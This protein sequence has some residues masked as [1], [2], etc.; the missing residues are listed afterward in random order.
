[1]VHQ[2]IRHNTWLIGSSCLTSMHWCI[3]RG[4]TFKFLSVF[5]KIDLSIRV[6][7]SEWIN[8][9]GGKLKIHYHHNRMSDILTSDLFY[10]NTVVL[11]AKKQHISISVI[12]S[13]TAMSRVQ[14]CGTATRKRHFKLPSNG[15]AKQILTSRT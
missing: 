8:N 13:D 9:A 12:L 15:F 10:H 1:M 11:A 5:Q 4:R 3:H 2:I 7:F 14:L 6:I